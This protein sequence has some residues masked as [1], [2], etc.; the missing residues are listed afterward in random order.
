VSLGD[1]IR[2]PGDHPGHIY[3]QFVIRCSR[4]DDLQ[5]YLRECGVGTEIY[6]PV[7]LHL[8]P[9]FKEL[10]YG[11]AD[12]P[13]AEAAARDSLALPIYPELPESAIRYV[14]DQ[15]AQFSR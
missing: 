11:E 6:Y 3:N 13:E 9:C 4:R 8:Q 5:R 15:V 2:V 12:M 14:V 1:R 10:G 7:S